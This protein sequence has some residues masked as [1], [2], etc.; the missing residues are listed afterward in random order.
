MANCLASAIELAQVL[1]IILMHTSNV[2][3]IVKTHLI[4]SPFSTVVGITSRM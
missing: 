1:K 3:N 4:I 2:G